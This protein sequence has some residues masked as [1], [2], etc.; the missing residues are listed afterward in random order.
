MIGPE[1][2]G[3]VDTANFAPGQVPLDPA[4]VS[5]TGPAAGLPLLTPGAGPWALALGL[6]VL[7]ALR[8]RARSEGR[9]QPS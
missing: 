8:A 1:Y 7:G 2:G 3:I 6:G 9:A 4:A 5:Y